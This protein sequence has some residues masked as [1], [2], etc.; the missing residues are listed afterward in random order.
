[1]Q[2]FAHDCTKVIHSF[3][4]SN[5]RPTPS[6]ARQKIVLQTSNTMYK[7]QVRETQR[8]RKQ[9]IA[10]YRAECR[11]LP[12]KV[13]AL[14]TRSANTY[15]TKCRH[16]PNNAQAP[17]LPHPKMDVTNTCIVQGHNIWL[18]HRKPTITQ[19]TPHRGHI[20]L[21]NTN[22]HI[23]FSLADDSC[24]LGHRTLNLLSPLLPTSESF[25]LK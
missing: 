5:P 2:F 15:Q 25:V 20:Q 9:C 11:H 24:S 12:T 7:R 1:M 19:P 8:E 14:T 6:E 22:R 10:T 17:I 3:Q 16:L 4:H 21:F 18:S 23:P 13:W